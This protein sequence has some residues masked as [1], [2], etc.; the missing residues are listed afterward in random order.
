MG[1]Q[2]DNIFL[3]FKLSEVEKKKYDKVIKAFT[4]HFVTKTNVIYERAKFNLRY[5]I[6]GE[7]IED[8]ITDLH[9]LSENCEYGTL[10]EEMIRDR[11]VVGVR[12]R[13]LSEKLQLVK[14]L[15]LQKAVDEVR[16]HYAV[17]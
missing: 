16:Q 4:D 8:F 14:D 5:Q 3:S 11:I 9:M 17:R 12:D 13:K 7:L 10:K 15:T 6:E 1:D 2:A